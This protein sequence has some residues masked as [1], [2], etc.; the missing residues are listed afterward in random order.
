[1]TEKLPGKQEEQLAEML[2]GDKTL[3]KATK[4]PL[5]QR[6]KESLPEN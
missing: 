5:G 2:A 1:V 6:K 4:E 3:E